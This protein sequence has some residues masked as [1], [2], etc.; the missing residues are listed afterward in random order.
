MDLTKAR[1]HIPWA[2]LAELAEAQGFNVV[3]MRLPLH[4]YR[5]PRI[6]CYRGVA[7]MA[8]EPERGVVAGC[9]FADLCMGLFLMPRVDDVVALSAVQ[10]DNVVDGAQL[11]QTCMAK[12]VAAQ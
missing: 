12:P 11:A 2:L 7:A 3:V 9:S 5:M 6:V 1:E 10:V 4:L 8:C